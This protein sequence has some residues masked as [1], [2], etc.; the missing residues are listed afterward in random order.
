MYATGSKA[1]QTYIESVGA[2]FID[3]DDIVEAY[4]ARHTAGRGFDLVYDTVGGTVLDTSF[5]AVR[6][7]GHEVS[8]LGWGTH[9][10]APLSFRAATY[11]GV[12]TL[13]PLLSGEGRAHHGE[14]LA[15]ATRLAEAGKLVSLL[16]ARRFTL[17]T[18]AD[19]YA[20]I[21]DRDAKGTL[22]VGP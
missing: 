11:S 22:I 5:T 21:R 14:I 7:F 3:R 17:Q 20:L 15:E 10:L 16:D 4:V 1:Q 13:L 12:F 19:A 9:A 8:A 6:R 2:T 18:V